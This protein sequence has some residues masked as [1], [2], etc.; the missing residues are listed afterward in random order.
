V[1][2]SLLVLLMFACCGPAIAAERAFWPYGST[3]YL[4][5]ALWLKRCNSESIDGNKY[6]IGTDIVACITKS[7]N[8][9]PGDLLMTY[10]R[11]FAKRDRDK[12]HDSSENPLLPS[13]KHSR[14]KCLDI[15]LG[16]IC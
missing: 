2:K 1:K 14:F 15:K 3:P 12:M 8:G 11:R 5:Y 10:A 9:K 7:A 6:R 13:R 16:W 4:Y